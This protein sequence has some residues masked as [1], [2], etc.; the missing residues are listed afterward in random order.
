[1]VDVQRNVEL[2]AEVPDEGKICIGFGSRPDAVVDVNGGESDPQCVAGRCI[3]FM[4]CEEK[5]D[6]VGPAGDSYAEAVAWGDVFAI[7]G[8]RCGLSHC[9]F[10][11]TV[12]C[13]DHYPFLY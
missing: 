9:F 5:G 8:K 12:R 10:M 1:M 4:K 13:V 11:L 3:G 6:R 7:E 2:N